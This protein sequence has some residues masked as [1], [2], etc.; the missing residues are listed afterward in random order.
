MKRDS[1]TGE[2]LI[3]PYILIGRVGDDRLSTLFPINVSTFKVISGD[4]RVLS[5]SDPKLN[6]SENYEVFA[7]VSGP[8]REDGDFSEANLSEPLWARTLL[9]YFGAEILK[10]RLPRT[11]SELN[12][13]AL[14]GEDLSIEERFGDTID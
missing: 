13:E 7:A 11:Y 8:L 6:A 5:P 14:E 2:R 12:P 1:E 3:N 9:G 10:S 4:I